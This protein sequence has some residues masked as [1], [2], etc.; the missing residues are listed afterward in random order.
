MEASASWN[1][2]I[3]HL[4]QLSISV[5]SV[6]F[7]TGHDCLNKRHFSSFRNNKTFYF[8][9]IMFL[10]F[11]IEGYI[12]KY[13]IFCLLI[14]KCHEKTKINNGLIPLTSIVCLSKAWF[15]LFLCAIE[16]HYAW[17]TRKAE[18]PQSA[19]I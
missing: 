6:T 18:A 12:R 1:I 11:T 16:I 13:S 4:Q 10:Y 9:Y 3:A 19:V 8:S 5:I 15:I 14:N 7:V 17:D 2:H